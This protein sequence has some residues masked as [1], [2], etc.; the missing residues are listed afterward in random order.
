MFLLEHSAANR[1]IDL[2]ALWPVAVP[3]SPLLGMMPPSFEPWQLVSYSFLHGSIMHLLL[4]MYALWLFG[5][6][7]ENVWGSKV[8]ALYY[9]VCVMGAGLVQLYVASQAAKQG[10]VYP[11]IG[12][13]GGVF[14][15]LLA[16]G[17]TFP[18]E[19]LMLIFPPIVLKAKWFVL[20]YGAI[21]LWAGVTGTEAG[22]AHFAH[23]GGMFFGLAL[24]LY[25]RRYPPG[26]R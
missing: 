13:S 1:L 7:M 12:A 15:L 17:M 6:R 16:F 22:V 18:N 23:L 9:F 3:V 24:L 19:R 25:W 11:T 26:F 10:G 5:T 14:G 2:L 20:I 21:E 8:F 4:N